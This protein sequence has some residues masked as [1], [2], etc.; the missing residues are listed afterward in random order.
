MTMSH[1][2]GSAPHNNGHT[3]HYSNVAL[4]K[5]CKAHGLLVFIDKLVPNFNACTHLLRERVIEREIETWK[6][7]E[8]DARGVLVF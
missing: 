6:E 8:R 5:K 7:R 3:H 4:L 2:L 1:P